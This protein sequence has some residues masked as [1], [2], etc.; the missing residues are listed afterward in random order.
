M[1]KVRVI[2]PPEETVQEIYIDGLTMS[3]NI[4]YVHEVG[5]AWLQID[6]ISYDN[7]ILPE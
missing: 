6:S 5:N 1:L 3:D 2:I 7:S 4:V